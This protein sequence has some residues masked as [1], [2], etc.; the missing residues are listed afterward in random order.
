MPQDR[1][2]IQ[3]AASV[4]AGTPLELEYCAKLAWSLA[5]LQCL[6]PQLLS[7]AAESL[8]NGHGQDVVLHAWKH[9]LAQV[10]F[11]CVSQA[12]VPFF[13][14]YMTKPCFLRHSPFCVHLSK[15][16]RRVLACTDTNGVRDT[17]NWS[18]RVA[19]WAVPG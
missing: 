13:E 3:L 7:L 12:P 2:R 17:Y 8:K 6:D 9:M 16:H 11:I 1:A 15:L 18:P 19:L 4:Q 5:A 14:M 10:C